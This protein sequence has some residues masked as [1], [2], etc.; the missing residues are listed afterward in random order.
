M[1]LG[2]MSVKNRGCYQSWFSLCT[3]QLNAL[4]VIHVFGGRGSPFGSCT[5]A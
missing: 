5:A 2:L 1:V 4:S 3:L